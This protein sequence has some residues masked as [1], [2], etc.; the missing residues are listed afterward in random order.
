MP[1]RGSSR[2][3]GWSAL[4]LRAV[5]GQSCAHF[6]IGDRLSVWPDGTAS[7]ADA[8]DGAIVPPRQAAFSHR[9]REAWVDALQRVVEARPDTPLR[10]DVGFA[11]PLRASDEVLARARSVDG[12]R[13]ER[14][15]WVS[16]V[17]TH[18]GT[19]DLRRG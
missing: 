15:G 10:I 19:K 14:D 2:A 5:L 12:Y 6:A 1:D 17:R 9:N 13:T 8:I 3:H 16:V 4:D 18:Q 7:V 11:D